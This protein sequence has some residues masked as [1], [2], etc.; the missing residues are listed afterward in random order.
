MQSGLENTRK[1]ESNIEFIKNLFL[2]IVKLT[3]DDDIN[4]KQG[5]Y[6]DLEIYFT[7]R[8]D[9][10][11]LIYDDFKDEYVL[12][13]YNHGSNSNGSIH[14]HRQYATLSLANM[15]KFI[16]TVHNVNK[17]RPPKKQSKLEELF[18]QIKKSK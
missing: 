18:E 5:A 11:K 12:L 6:G 8:G 10:Y 17:Y 4:F 9:S 15:V 14:Y 3:L 13:H 1:I 2:N 7:L 16:S